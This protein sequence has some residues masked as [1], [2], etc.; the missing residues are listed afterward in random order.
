[1]HFDKRGAL[2]IFAALF[3][4]TFARLGNADATLFGDGAHS[5]GKRGFVHLHHELKN[6][7]ALAAAE[8]MVEL[9]G[10]VNGERRRF[11]LMKGAEAAEI[12]ATLFQADVFAD[13]ANDVRL[14][15]D[16]IRE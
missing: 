1:M 13:D 14:L 15:L 10:G 7:A 16:A 4:R 9:L 5:F 2:L 11:F 3:G 6:V 12:L 8:A